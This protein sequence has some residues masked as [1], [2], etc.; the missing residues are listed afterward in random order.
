LSVASG[1]ATSPTIWRERRDRWDVEVRA[2]GTILVQVSE[3]LDDAAA[4]D[5]SSALHHAA[6]RAEA[7]KR[8]DEDG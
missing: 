7:L 8:R 3:P 6:N 5:L 4:R 1:S 2:D